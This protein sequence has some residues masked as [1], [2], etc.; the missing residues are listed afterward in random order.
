MEEGSAEMTKQFVDQV[1]NIKLSALNMKKLYTL[2][3]IVLII[4]VVFNEKTFEVTNKIFG[5]KVL[6]NEK[7]SMFGYIL[8]YFVSGLLIFLTLRYFLVFPVEKTE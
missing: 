5:G 7:I 1:L 2:A 6:N 8:H 3:I 4:M